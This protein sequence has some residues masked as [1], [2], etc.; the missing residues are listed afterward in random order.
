MCS[1]WRFATHHVDARSGSTCTAK[2]AAALTKSTGITRWAVGAIFLPVRRP[3][4]H[5]YPVSTL[6]TRAAYV[7]DSWPSL[8]EGRCPMIVLFQA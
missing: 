6:R 2:E 8:E 4:I 5:L 1:N 7:Q 3:D